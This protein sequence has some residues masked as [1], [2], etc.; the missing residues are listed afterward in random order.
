ML[1]YALAIF[2]G[3]FLLFQ[4]QPLI[5]KYIL[6][7]FGGSPGVWTTCML[8]FQLLLLC[9]YA[10]AHLIA[11]RF[12]RR[13]QAI[14]YGTALLAAMAFLPV[15]PPEA[16][17]PDG[18]TEPTLRILVLLAV[19]VGLPYFVLA[20]TSPL[21]QSWFARTHPGPSPYR[22]YA[23]SNAG[24]LLALLSYPFVIEPLLS[25]QTQAY[26][27]SFAFVSYALLGGYCA[28]QLLRHDAAA[29]DAA[30]APT[31][32]ALAWK[33]A[34]SVR[35]LWVLLPACGSLLLLAITNEVTIDVA[36]V[37]FLWVLPLGIYLLTFIISFD[38]E[39]WYSR[40]VFFVALI[41]SLI[42]ILPML[43]DTSGVALGTQLAV[44]SI[45]LFVF[46]MVC[47]GELARHKPPAR[48]LTS[49]YLSIAAGGALGS[50]FVAVVAPLIFV[51]YLELHVGLVLCC[52][53]FMA[54]LWTSPRSWLQGGRPR[55]AWIAMALAVLA[56]GSA[57][58]VGAAT[59]LAEATE[60]S[61]NFY[62]VLNIFDELTGTPGH[63]V[64]LRHGSTLHGL[65]FVHATR[66][67]FPTSY[68]GGLSG[69]GLAL[70]AFP[71]QGARRIGVVGLGIGTLTAYSRPG[72]YV[73]I[74]EINPE[75]KRLAETRFTFL[76]HAA[77]EIDI[78]MGDARLS[79][80][81][82]DPQEFDVLLL[83]AFSSDAIPVHLLTVEAFETYLRHLRPDGVLAVH[84][85]NRHLAL[86]PVVRRL[87]EHFG[88][89]H[90]RIIS[91][92]DNH[93]GVFESDWMLLTNNQELLAHPA[94]RSAAAPVTAAGAAVALWTDDYINIL[95]I[96]DW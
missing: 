28:L 89:E 41:G 85:S 94:I 76:S 6:P 44:Y 24:S 35:L 84:I 64:K 86:A 22:L 60:M 83:D 42:A 38:H 90:R 12:G 69:A 43:G 77:A 78:V 48:F 59:E 36:P 23:L 34:V 40:P 58:T 63:M 55:W 68:Y 16:L 67:L 96:V 72:E 1:A 20:S 66:T 13:G 10:F 25:R 26:V 87:A 9:G 52:V 95:E 4:V 19:S 27:W 88:L 54:S 29:E 75:V 46:C 15:V 47:H 30:E 57:L 51:A 81:R 33:P 3:A 93:R 5:A 62:G 91:S 65:Q 73:R 18:A 56:F 61:R 11:S 8:F 92:E 21:M 70:R 45:A 37:P 82:E 31:A 50:L 49:Y 80:E 7:W 71:R 14:A 2:T 17:K 74:Y 32:F 39:R 79:M 53:L